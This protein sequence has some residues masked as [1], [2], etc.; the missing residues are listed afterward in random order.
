MGITL[1]L[2]R[3]NNEIIV[4]EPQ[5]VSSLTNGFYG[6]MD[7][8]IIHLQ[9]EEAL[10]MIDIR[11]AKCI[12]ETGNTYTF[13]DIASIFLKRKKLLARY[14]TFKDWRDRGL[15]VRPNFEAHRNYGRSTTKK[16][17]GGDF[18]IDAYSLQGVFFFDDL[19]TIIDD[20]ASGKELYEKYWIGQ[21]GTYKAAHRGKIAKLDIHETIYLLKH[22]NL[23][24]K[25]TKLKEIW[26]EANERIK[27][28]EDMY[29]VYEN[30]R[31]KG[32]VLKTGFKFGTHFR[33]YFPGASPIREND[34]WIHSRHVVHIFPRKSKMLISEWSR[35]IRVAHSVKKT[36]ILAIPGK[37]LE[38]KINPK[39]PRL[40]FLLYHRKKG[41][42]ETPKNGQPR[43]FMYSLSEDEYLGGEELAE[44]LFEVKYYGLE[45]LLAIADRESSI[46]FYVVKRIEL[47]GSDYEHYEIEWMQP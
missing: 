31:N 23:S 6:K 18:K 43:F 37:K 13:N 19:I 21:F 25:N 12:D 24:L 11:N 29:S 22:G 45:A 44:V 36:F 40:D 38:I 7:K 15:I 34:E 3:K 8:G 26:V 35:A 41:G 27:Y 20:E 4:K 14:L 1:Y 10:Y 2:N 5:D 39:K 47:P 17:K 46:T 9:P 16:Y 33:I 28:F 42:I 32:Y 30:W